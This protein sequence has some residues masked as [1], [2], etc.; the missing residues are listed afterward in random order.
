MTVRIAI[1]EYSQ[2][3]PRKFLSD[4]IGRVLSLLYRY[5]C[6]IENKVN[7]LCEGV[8]VSYPFYG[9]CL[10][11]MLS[12]CLLLWLLRQTSLFTTCVHADEMIRQ[13]LYYYFLK[14]SFFVHYYFSQV[15]K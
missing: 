7:V 2:S 11:V 3:L 9:Y 1:A 12:I 13:Y 6:E 10:V 5:D 8:Y 15:C 14:M 4:E